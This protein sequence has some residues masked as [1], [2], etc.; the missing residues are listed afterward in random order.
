MNKIVLLSILIGI[1]FIV[2]CD[3]FTETKDATLAPTYTTQV[4]GTPVATSPI[5]PNENVK[6]ILHVGANSDICNTESTWSGEYNGS[7]MAPF[8]IGPMTKPF[9]VNLTV[10]DHECKSNQNLS[11]VG[12][13]WELDDRSVGGKSYFPGDVI[14]VIIDD[15]HQ[16]RTLLFDHMLGVRTI[17]LPRSGTK[18]AAPLE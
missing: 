4:T 3:L 17:V 2:S 12:H 1:F 16:N 6:Y 15:E 5:S 8:D 18:N 14:T 10:K 9:T 11:Y 7:K 13:T